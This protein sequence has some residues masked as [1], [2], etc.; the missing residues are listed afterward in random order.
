MTAVVCLAAITVAAL[1]AAWA[2][3]PAGLTDGLLFLMPI[4]TGQVL[5]A[6]YILSGLNLFGS[7]DAWAAV[8]AASLVAAAVIRPI[9]RADAALLSHAS[10]AQFKLFTGHFT[11]AY[12]TLTR[13]ERLLL[14]SC[15]VVVAVLGAVNLGLVV[16]T[17]PH[18]WDSMTYQ[19]ARMAYYLQ[20]GNLDTFDANFWAQVVHP[21]NSTVLLS[22]VYLVSSRNENL[23]QLVQYLSYW[24]AMGSVYGISRQIGSDRFSSLMAGLLFGLLIECLMQASTTQNDLLITA[25]VGC[26]TYGLFAWCRRG[27]R[28]YLV[29]AAFASAFAVGV[30]ASALLVIPS[31][32]VLTI[33]AAIDRYRR[34]VSDRAAVN[35]SGAARRQVGRRIAS[36]LSLLMACAVVATV[37]F[38]LPSG[39]AANWRTFGHA[40]GPA[41]VREL[42]SFEG[43]SASYVLANGSRNVLRYAFEFVSLDG[44][45]SSFGRL[46]E[47]LRAPLREMT[48]AAGV[49]LETPVASRVPFTYSKAPMAAEDASYWGILG[50]GLVWPVALLS[51][52][53]AGRSR[54]AGVLAGAALLFFVVQS[55]A[56][57]YDPWRGRYFM[58]AAIFALP[59]VSASSRRLLRRPVG[60]YLTAVVIA[61]CLSALA[62]VLHPA[63]KTPLEI[64]R[65]DRIGQLTVENREYALPTR[66]F[67]RLVPATATVAVLFGGG[68]FEYPL[69]GEGLTRTLVPVNGFMRGLQRIPSEADYLIYSS[70]ILKDRRAS[71]I[72]LGED[73]YLRALEKNTPRS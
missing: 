30:K 29:M 20:H 27:E 48:L 68:A 1:L 33:F 17:A 71:D 59:A 8:A 15:V 60:A 4:Y 57:P 28:K 37:V 40:I 46:Q 62:A 26:A 56:G 61:G 42:H 73:W 6:G 53:G 10:H 45:P 43:E 50:F 54:P 25:Y 44:M 12:G 22:F 24:V 47:W 69:F 49:D 18:A 55:Y 5:V 38:V 7:I 13:V 41:E 72:H 58:T 2:T 64:R 52:L 39:Y 14:L 51:L 19:L 67:D 34:A 70:S 11:R 63:N 66:Q 21:K 32:A 16:G 23:T 31:L 3:R 65:L 35:V 36:D 9:G